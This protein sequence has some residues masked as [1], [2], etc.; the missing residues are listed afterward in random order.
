MT[1]KIFP[2]SHAVFLSCVLAARLGA[3]LASHARATPSKVFCAAVALASFS[4]RLALPG[5][6]PWS[7]SLRAASRLVRAS[8]RVTIGYFP[9]VSR[10]FLPFGCMYAMRQDFV[11]FGMT[12]R[13]MP[14]PSPKV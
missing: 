5:S 13:Y 8:A 6:I 9:K 4:S 7:S 3:V 1:G 12:S 11:P 2:S 14:S 10:F